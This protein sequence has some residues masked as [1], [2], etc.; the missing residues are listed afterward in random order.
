VSPPEVLVVGYGPVGATLALLLAQHGRRVTILERHF[1]P[2]GLPRAVHLDH[3]VMRILQG[4]GVAQRLEAAG[5]IEPAGAYE[6]RSA[7]GDVL[8]RFGSDR[9]AISGWPASNMVSQP[10]LERILADLVDASPFI[11]VERGAEVVAVE[12]GPEGVTVRL[13][14]GEARSAPFVA[15]CDGANSAVRDACGITSTDLGFFFDWLVVDVVLTEPR[16]YD[17]LNVQIC[18][19]RRPTT[20]VS[21]GPGRR[22]W[23]FMA[24]PGDAPGWLAAESTAW[25][26]LAP[27]DVHPGNARLER[28]AVYTFGARWVDEWCRGRVALAGD[29]AHQMP[30]FAGQGLCSGIRDA[31]NLA[32]KLAEVLAGRAPLSLLD[33]YQLE[34]S[35]DVR[36]AIDFSIA[37]GKVICI[38]DDAAAA[39][40]DATM[41][42]AYAANGPTVTA[43]PR[44]SLEA[45][46]IAEGTPLAG[47]PSLQWFEDGERVDDRC[48][49]GWRLVSTVAVDDPWWASIGGR[50]VAAGGDALAWLAGHGVG[51][52]LLRPDHLVFGGGAPADLVTQLRVR[53]SGAGG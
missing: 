49:G 18:D 4:V 19:P 39:E 21:G 36:R 20:L 27:H 11:T 53:L 9:T 44:P 6:W 51:A 52:V 41:T 38:A 42:A 45:G 40:R 34:R 15:G 50:T 35:A 26:L 32:W 28:H 25:E 2:Y 3:E 43:P 1:A 13:A 10:D 12:Q 47:S 17:P 33:T 16:V 8:L 30:P 23:E 29:A 14:S 46:I 24:V 22:R 48:G 31:A 7:G 5:A 37:L